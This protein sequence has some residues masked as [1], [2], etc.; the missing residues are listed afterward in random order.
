MPAT[1]NSF[2]YWRSLAQ[3]EPERL[4]DQFLSQLALLPPEARS[5]F[6]ASHP[7]RDTMVQQIKAACANE[8]GPL[9]GVPYMLQDLFDVDGL[10]TRCGAP[11][12]EPFES[13]LEDASLL[14][15]KLKSLGA[16]LLAKTTPS[17]F[18]VDPRGHNQSFGDCPHADGLRYVCGGG[19]GASAYAVRG[20]WV[21]MAFG[22]DGSAGIRI[23]A[24][25]N[26]LFGFRMSNNAYAREGVFP[27]VP[28]LDSVGWLTAQL[29]DLLTS[30]Q[31]F[32][33]A[34]TETS[35]EDNLR[36]YLFED[37]SITLDPSLKASL[38]NLVRKLDT[39]DESPETNKA[40]VKAFKDSSEAFATIEARELYAIHQYWVEEYRSSYD[41]ALLSR[42][43]AGQI[44]T[45]EKAEHASAVQQRVRESMVD[46]FRK[47]DYL[48][49]PISPCPTPDKAEWNGQLENDLLRLNA[50]TSL[51]FLPALIL[52]FP[53]ARG[54][55]SA[56]Q[57]IL[58]PRKMHL[59]VK[60]IKQVES[61]YN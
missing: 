20:G 2:E 40:L 38:M 43:E 46:F 8:E 49:M 39:D 50:P 18:G 55:H 44:C 36:G 37:P 60:L 26:G 61:Y 30:I 1:E 11:F 51:T 59:I 33:P 25:F 34:T 31:A 22:L 16:P 12:Q 9:L 28:S 7:E 13:D 3:N 45:S 27:I 57:L 47:Y 54:R 52:P 19:A 23:P 17:E 21:P 58:N 14:Y 6:V 56:I 42:I 24:A 5:A 35:K 53:C 15:Q 32:Q 10:P 48:I 41:H 4:A 29:D